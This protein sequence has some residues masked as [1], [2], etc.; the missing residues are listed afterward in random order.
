MTK[1]RGCGCQSHLVMNRDTSAD[2]DWIGGYLCRTDFF[3]WHHG[4][5]L[6]RNRNREQSAQ[7][8]T[9]AKLAGAC[10][11]AQMQSSNCRYLPGATG[12]MRWLRRPMGS[13]FRPQATTAARYLR[14]YGPSHGRRR[15]SPSYLSLQQFVQ[16]PNRQN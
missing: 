2:S 15:K 11:E 1:W 16:W 9:N 5:G 12:F 3:V 7:T 6:C 4:I 8:S 10:E 14:P 13:S